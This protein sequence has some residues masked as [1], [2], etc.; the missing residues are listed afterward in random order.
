MPAGFNTTSK[1]D[2][3]EPSCRKTAYHSREEA[4]AM[5]NHIRE[6]RITKEIRTYKC[7]ICGL[8]HLT[9]RKGNS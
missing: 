2:P 8:W 3:I 5:I 7:D 9:S 4:E 6:T 1:P